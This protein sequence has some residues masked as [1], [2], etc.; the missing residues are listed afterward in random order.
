MFRWRNRVT[1]TTPADRASVLDQW[2]KEPGRWL[3]RMNRRKVQCYYCRAHCAK[4]TARQFGAR[5]WGFFGF[6]CEKCRKGL[7]LRELRIRDLGNE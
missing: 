5:G 3:G 1:G 4:G 7:T 6:L 2:E